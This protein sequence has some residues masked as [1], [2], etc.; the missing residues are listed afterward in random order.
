[1]TLSLAGVFAD[2]RSLWRS[3]RE[4]LVPIAGVFYLL[5]ALALRLFLPQPDVSTLAEE[6]AMRAALAW[7][8][9]NA[10]W[11]AL[12]LVLQLLG[13]AVILVLLLDRERPP[14]GAAIGKG[15]ALL[16]RLIA[17]SALFL[18][19]LGALIMLLL[20]LGGPLLFVLVIAPLF[21]VL[22]RSFVLLP[23]LAAERETPLVSAVIAAL[24]RTAG[25]GWRLLLVMT[26]I[27]FPLML[28]SEILLGI[29]EKAGPIGGGIVAVVV[30]VV[31]AAAVLGQLLLQIAA[32]RL[33]AAAKQGM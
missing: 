22:G 24:R 11:F 16:P 31:G 17:G 21:Y 29:G 8:S 33:L 23:L 18:L 10:P 4:L 20:I 30:S 15:A 7:L 19:P 2:A 32:Y 6:E 26:M 25:N 5:P 13:S 12:Q 28:V 14:A 27:Y 1:M 9:T 3:T